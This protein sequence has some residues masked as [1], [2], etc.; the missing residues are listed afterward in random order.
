MVTI[1]A[2][3]VAGSTDVQRSQVAA[4]VATQTVVFSGPNEIIT[5][6]NGAYRFY[7]NPASDCDGTARFVALRG[8]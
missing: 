8:G 1:N 6:V 5:L 7:P 2:Q 3:T 4:T